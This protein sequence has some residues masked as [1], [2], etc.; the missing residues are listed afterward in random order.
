MSRSTARARVAARLLRA[1]ASATC[2]AAAITPESTT[3]VSGV[4]ELGGIRPAA[5]MAVST[6]RTCPWANRSAIS[7]RTSAGE[8]RRRV[9]DAH[10]ADRRVERGV[11]VGLRAEPEL[12]DRVV[13]L[14]GRDRHPVHHLL[15]ELLHHRPEEVLLVGEVVV[16]RAAGHAGPAHDLL[17]TRCREAALAEQLPAGGEQGGP[18]GGGAFGLRAARC[19]GQ[20]LTTAASRR[21]MRAA[22]MLL[23]SR[24]F[25]R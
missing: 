2:W 21:K 13:G 4:D 24:G 16:E 20:A 18:G 25:G 19:A 22:C 17:P 3:S 1:S 10:A 9:D 12:L 23:R 14:H 7:R 15:L 11:E 6:S 8:D 5:P